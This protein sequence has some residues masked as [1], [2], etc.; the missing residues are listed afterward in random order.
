MAEQV[1]FSDIHVSIAN[2]QFLV[3]RLHS[4]SLPCLIVRPTHH[5][6]TKNG[7]GRFPAGPDGSDHLAHTT[8]PL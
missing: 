6:A 4:N 8:A 2:Q 1:D 5:S 3:H 7:S